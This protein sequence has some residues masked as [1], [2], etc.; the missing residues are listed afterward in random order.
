M[1]AYP[2]G[3]SVDIVP[4]GVSKSQGINKLLELMNW[5]DAEVYA[6]GDESNDLPML[7]AFDGF[8]VDTARDAIKA[9]AREV[10]AGVGAMLAANL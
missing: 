7:E 10:Y 1:Q 6:I 4:A 3:C 5:Q 2:N 8:T 9:R